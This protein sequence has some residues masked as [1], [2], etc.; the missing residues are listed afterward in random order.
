[1]TF[2]IN[3]AYYVFDNYTLSMRH[4]NV[5]QLLPAL[6]TVQAPYSEIDFSNFVHLFPSSGNDFDDLSGILQAVSRARLMHD[7]LYHFIGSRTNPENTAD[8]LYVQKNIDNTLTNVF[9]Q[10]ISSITSPILSGFCFILLILSYIWSIVF[11]FWFFKLTLPMLVS[12]IRHKIYAYRNH[13][14]IVH[15]S[16]SDLNNDNQNVSEDSDSAESDAH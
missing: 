16:R 13:S 3:D 1:M 14:V 5:Q 15:A 10:M 4:E 2:L 9:L 11:T 12:V 7:Q 8:M 6:I